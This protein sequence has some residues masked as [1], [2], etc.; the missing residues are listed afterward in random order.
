ML[1]IKKDPIKDIKS[2]EFGA[3]DIKCEG[4]LYYSESQNHWFIIYN[5]ASKRSHNFTL[6]HEFG[7]YCLHREKYTKFECSSEDVNDKE[8]TR[9]KD[10]E[11]EADTFAS[12][13]LMPIDDFRKQIDGQLD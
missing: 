3:N 13:L 2:T 12:Y 6:A 7:H 8:Y 11:R 4:A 1:K 9:F 10:I 5:D